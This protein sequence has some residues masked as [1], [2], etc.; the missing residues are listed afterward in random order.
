MS[1]AEWIPKADAKPIYTQAMADHNILP[2][3]GMSCMIYYG[4][5]DSRYNDFFDVEIEILAVTNGVFT[6]LNPMLG[7]A[8][9]SLDCKMIKPITPPIELID[10]EAYKIN[11]E[12]GE[13]ANVIYN[14][15]VKMF[16]GSKSD[17]TPEFCTNI[18]HLT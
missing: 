7:L 4:E 9:L 1:K 17:Y 13:I 2:R 10:G 8:A 3:V 14:D 16:I 11:I 18:K 5:P 6:F 12:N 15:E